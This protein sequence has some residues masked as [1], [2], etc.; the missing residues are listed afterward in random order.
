MRGWLAVL[1]SAMAVFVLCAC[2]SK[3]EVAALRPSS[4]VNRPISRPPASLLPPETRGPT[5]SALR[6]VAL[7]AID[8]VSSSRGRRLPASTRWGKPLR[9]YDQLRQIEGTSGAMA[10][11]FDPSTSG[12]LVPLD[13]RSGPEGDFY[14]SPPPP[15]RLFET[16]D[17]GHLAYDR[18]Q[19]AIR[20]VFK[21]VGPAGRV[22]AFSGGYDGAYGEDAQ[23][24]STV[25][26]STVRGLLVG[27][28]RTTGNAAPDASEFRVYSGAEARQLLIEVVQVRGAAAK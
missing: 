18:F 26:F 8:E 27:E 24:K 15:Y 25:V 6:T 22:V 14:T 5:P 20:M 19:K 28:D 11:R 10:A 3:A 13:S 21:V 7:K 2:S 23:G 4:E 9:V 1:V 16:G 17:G 12:W